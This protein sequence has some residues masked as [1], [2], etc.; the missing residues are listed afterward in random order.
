MMILNFG[1]I[2]LGGVLMLL[3]AAIFPYT[4]KGGII[5]VATCVVVAFVLHFVAP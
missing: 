2:A 5:A 1:K 3:T 4:L